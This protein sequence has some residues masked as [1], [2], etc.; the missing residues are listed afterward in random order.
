MYRIIIVSSIFFSIMLQP[1]SF[2][3]QGHRGARGLLPENSI[4]A[5]RKALELGVNTLELDVAISKD[6]QV[7]VSHEPWLSFDICLTPEGDRIPPGEEQKYNLYHLDYEEIKKYDC[8][9]LGN[10]GFPDQKR[11]QVHKPLLTDVF[12]M[13]EKYCKDEMR[14]EIYYNIE[15]KSNPEWDGMFHPDYQDFCDLVFT[16]IDA[17]VPWKRVIIQSF[18]FRVLQYFHQT[19]PTVRLSALEESE[20]D[21]E[22]VLESLGFFPEIYSPYYKLLKPKKIEWLHDQGVNVIPWTV[23]EAKEMVELIEMGVDGIITDYPDRIG[24]IDAE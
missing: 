20:S 11:V 24:L 5:F 2:D 15:I 3:W 14:N 23:N 1:Q 22:K 4:P 19:Y 9:S 16:T 13:A 6:N 17:Y 18:D 7:V 12:R 21:P 10:P 8:G